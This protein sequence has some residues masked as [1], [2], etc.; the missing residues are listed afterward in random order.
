MS[1]AQ[2]T[3][4]VALALALSKITGFVREIVIAP[5]LGYGINTDA[6]FIG[7]QIPDLVYQL[8]IGGAIGAALT[9]F[10]SSGLEKG[11]ERRVWRSVSIFMNVF[12]LATAVAIIFGII[13][14]PGIISSYNA[15]KDP[16][17]ISRDR[18][19]VV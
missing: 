5:T 19:S 9:P 10:M 3:F 16:V 18:K 1:V 12:L 8:M 17:V 2:S 15:D 6:Y 4:V 14:A 7:F 11:Q 13:F